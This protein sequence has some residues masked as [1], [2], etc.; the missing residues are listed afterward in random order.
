MN[1][2]VAIFSAA[3]Q[4]AMWKVCGRDA[5][6]MLLKPGMV[7]DQVST[8]FEREVCQITGTS[9]MVQVAS[10][11][12]VERKTFSTMNDYKNLLPHLEFTHELILTSAQ[13]KTL[14]RGDASTFELWWSVRRT[15]TGATALVLRNG[16]DWMILY[17][18]G[19]HTGNLW[20]RDIRIQ[21]YAARIKTTNP[22]FN[23][24]WYLDKRVKQKRYI[25]QVVSSTVVDKKSGRISI[26]G[27][28]PKKVEA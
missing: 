19:T 22:S 27:G 9:A 5:H 11:V 8:T 24:S 28:L 3:K 23:G 14:E 4:N 2:E 12:K 10:T 6:G 21:N 17:E 25:K 20:T 18:D 13:R 7:L 15:D 16:G 26:R 1:L